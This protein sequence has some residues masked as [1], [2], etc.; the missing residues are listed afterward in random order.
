MGCGASAPKAAAGEE[1]VQVAPIDKKESAAPQGESSGAPAAPPADANVAAAPADTSGTAAVAPAEPNVAA[2]LADASGTSRNIVIL[3]GP[4]GAGKGS[5][6]PK[7]VETLGIPQLSTGDMLRAAVAAGTEVGLQADS[8]M[9]SGGLVSDSLVVSII[10]DRIKED[11]CKGGFILDGFPRTVEQAKMLDEMLT[12]SNEKVRFVVALEVPDKVL[13]ERICGRWIHKSSGRSYHAT[14]PKLRPKSLP[15]GATPSAENML[16]DETSEP[17]MQRADDT[18]E[19]LKSR[20]EAYHAQTVPILAHYEPAGSVHRVKA[21][22][23]PDEVWASIEKVLKPSDAPATAQVEAPAVS[24]VGET[25]CRNVLILFGPPGAGKGS[26]APKI[27]ETLGIP[28]LSTGDMLRAAVAAGTEVGLQADSVMKSGGLVS[29]SLVVS[30]IKD[31][32]KEDDCK[33]G[34]ILDGFPRTVE[35]AQMLDEMLAT[36]G[37]KVRFVIALEVADA[38]LEERICGRWIHK[39]S[40]RSYHATIPQFRP[41]SLPEG[42]AP[43]AENMLDD[44]T[45]EPLMQRADDTKDAL[46][47]RLEGYHAQ[48]VPILAHYDPSGS[49]RRVDASAAPDQVWSAIQTII[50]A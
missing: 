10:K 14:N 6:A 38:L 26:Q 21:D 7:I 39:A 12:V 36:S 4:P 16:D 29:D 35:Q 44:E 37:E 47:K 13:T 23:A 22:V 45:S 48:T 34:F 41:K 27:V 32:I 46:M 1:N 30:I 20:L 19:A 3:F 40:G 9:K 50:T 42:E 24:A 15:E 17:L 2:P 49:V 28:Q 25:S 5:Q 11:D 43:T 18:E 33:G 31:R 8:V